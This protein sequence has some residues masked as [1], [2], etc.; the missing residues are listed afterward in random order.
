MLK[1]KD[2]LRETSLIQS[3]LIAASV[4]MG[5]LVLALFLRLYFLQVTEHQRFATL[6]QENRIRLVPIPPVR[7]QIYDRKG[8]ILAENLPVYTLEVTPDRVADM[9]ALLDRVG[10]LV[11]LTEDDLE[12]FADMLRSRPSFETQTLKAGLSDAEVARFT[13]NQHRFEGI[14]LRARLQRYYPLGTEMVHVLGYVGRISEDDLKTIDR[15]AYSGTDY[16]GKL[17]IEARYE[18]QLLGKV[19]YERVETNAH[20][21]VVRT[22]ERHHPTAGRHLYLNVDADLQRAAREYLGEFEGSVVAMEPSTGA[23]LAFVSNPVY[24]P[25]PFV[26]GI[27]ARSYKALRESEARPLLNR[28][29]NGRYAPGSTIK[30]VFGLAALEHHRHPDHGAF[31]PGFFRLKGSRHRYRCWKRQGHGNVGLHNA[32]VQS[33]DV[34]FYQ[35]SHS[36]G[37]DNVSE[38][39]LR[40]GF[41]KPTGIDL[42]GEPGGLVPTKAWKRRVRREPWYPG[43]T[44]ITGIGQGY[45]LTTPLQL[46]SITATLAQRGQRMRPRLVAALEDPQSRERELLPP[47]VL[48]QVPL[49]SD[50]FYDTV[51]AAMRDVVHGRRGTAR[52]SGRGAEYEFAGKTGTA[53]VIGIAQGASYDEEKIAKKFRDHSL[54]IAFAPIDDP[55]IAVAVIAENGGGGSRT[56][57]PIARKVMDHYLVGPPPPPPPPEVKDDE[58]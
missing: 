41:G 29:L 26:D 32:I 38:F 58:A 13:V 6:S 43:E 39:M 8:T 48:E 5:L 36:L 31:C 30:P 27:D 42:I 10:R 18:E 47:E 46:A 57:A 11:E 16:I 19:G 54:F 20:G 7:G 2:Y 28:A 49:R 35:L 52:A 44:V 33:C 3:R 51:F 21:R 22:L 55:K 12:R 25:N 15:A 34:Y 14:D 50:A 37:I 53:Q 17:G 45:T 23:V 1:L 4:I 9:D 56:A 24:D 40:Y